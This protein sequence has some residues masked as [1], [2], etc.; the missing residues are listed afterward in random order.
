ML[1]WP[2]FFLLIALCARWL[3][4]HQIAASAA[5]M[6]VFLTLLFVCFALLLWSRGRR[7]LNTAE[8]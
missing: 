8:R 1:R 6:S 2:L 5:G 3:G 7:R 4:F